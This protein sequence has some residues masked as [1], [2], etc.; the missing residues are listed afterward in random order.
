MEET[1]LDVIELSKSFSEPAT[2]ELFD[3][4]SL[5]VAKGTTVAITGKSGVGKSTLLQILGSLEQ[6]DSGTIILDGKPLEHY[7][8][9]FLRNRKIGFL[10]QSANLLDD[11][12]LLDN[13]LLPASIARQPTGKGSEHREYA[14][15]LLEKVGLLDRA[16]FLAKRLSGGEKQRAALARALVNAPTLLL[17]DEPSGNLDPSTAA[18]MHK[19]IIELCRELNMTAVIVT[20]NEV[21]AKVCDWHYQLVNKQLT[22][23]SS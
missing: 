23:C 18:M 12:T 13:L 7:E 4:L 5:K 10:F 8:L 22:L 21:L 19:L 15:M 20:H 2:V 17:A 14:L 1:A 9:P 16:D 11:Y 3:K 6:S